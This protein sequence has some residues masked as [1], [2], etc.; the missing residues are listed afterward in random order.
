LQQSGPSPQRRDR[1]QRI[2]RRRDLWRFAATHTLH[3]VQSSGRR[4]Q[5]VMA[6]SWLIGGRRGRY[7]CPPLWAPGTPLVCLCPEG[8]WTRRSP[9]KMNPEGR[10]VARIGN[11]AERIRVAVGCS[12]E[13]VSSWLVSPKARGT[14]HSNWELKGE[15]TQG[16]PKNFR[17]SERPSNLREG[18]WPKPK[19]SPR[20]RS[21]LICRKGRSPQRRCLNGLKNRDEPDL[22]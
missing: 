4:R 1:R 21:I 16:R 5:P 7:R 13:S 20:A 19:I 10:H 3:R 6:A 12:R 18:N 11:R 2:S 22:A 14:F 17:T 9:D 8:C 15:S